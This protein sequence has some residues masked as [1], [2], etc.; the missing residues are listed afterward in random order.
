MS[1]FYTAALEAGLCAESQ[2][3]GLSLARKILPIKGHEAW[4]TGHP[5]PGVPLQ[6]SGLDEGSGIL[7]DLCMPRVWH[8]SAKSHA[9]PLPSG[10]F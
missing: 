7:G 4:G 3:R 2:G 1:C 5:K 8:S 10:S 6:W 9:R